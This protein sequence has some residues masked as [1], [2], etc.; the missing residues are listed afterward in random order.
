[1]QWFSETSE[2]LLEQEVILEILKFAGYDLSKL[3]TEVNTIDKLFSV[4]WDSAI[5]S[6]K[7]NIP[8]SRHS[9]FGSVDRNTTKNFARKCVGTVGEYLLDAVVNSK[10]HGK[11][12]PSNWVRSVHRSEYGIPDLDLGSPDRVILDIGGNPFTFASI[13]FYAP[14]S[15]KWETEA[16]LSNAFYWMSVSKKDYPELIG[17][18]TVGLFTNQ[19][20]PRFMKFNGGMM[21][22]DMIRQHVDVTN[23]GQTSNQVFWN[24]FWK[25]LES[26]VTAGKLLVRNKNLAAPRKPD[27]FQTVMVIDKLNP[28]GAQT[29]VGPCAFGKMVMQTSLIPKYRSINLVVSGVRLVLA[30]QMYRSMKRDI[31]TPFNCIH[32][33]SGQDYH[34]EYNEF[35]DVAKQ[36]HTTNANQIANILIKYAQSKDELPLHVLTIEQSLN[37]VV[38]AF[39]MIEDASVFD[40]E[41]GETLWEKGSEKHL[42][43][44]ERIYKL[45]T[46]AIY[47]EAH[48]LVTG[49]PVKGS[50][51]SSEDKEDKRKTSYL[52]DLPFLNT[53]FTRSTYWTATRRLNGSKRDMANEAMF[54]QVVACV[55]PSLAI[56][57]GY[58]VRPKV[59]PYS[60]TDGDIA[61]IESSM[62]LDDLKEDS[63]EITYYIKCLEHALSDCRSRDLPCQIMVF[64]DDASK[65]E[66]F[67]EIVTKYF[68]SE[69][70][71]ADVVRAETPQKDRS[72][73]FE[74]FSTSKFSVLFNYAIVHEGVDIDSCTGVILGRVLNEI[75]LVQAIGRS[76]RLLKE[77]REHRFG[78]VDNYRKQYG[79]VYTLVDQTSASSGTYWDSVRDIYWKITQA[80][81]DADWLDFRVGG[82]TS[83]TKGIPDSQVSNNQPSTVVDHTSN[84]DELKERLKIYHDEM[85]ERLNNEMVAHADHKQALAAEHHDTMNMLKEW[86]VVL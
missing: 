40:P 72:A 22:G 17:V 35:S 26:N 60:I 70:L 37:K 78:D 28:T 64:V 80:T 30:S 44:K 65:Q 49:D 18:N 33:M 24:D 47:D 84:S 32:V 46:E 66:K 74:R 86:G 57:M 36:H 21:T 55:M 15:K 67:A 54:G 38:K 48:N 13:K 82:S 8:L 1:M 59:I 2:S 9:I 76:Q 7:A 3:Q 20:E 14:F 4:V 16:N 27:Q 39:R 29:A 50:G 75:W 31:E 5:K 41:T 73:I 10:Q 11:L 69:G 71:V 19:S 63:L 23:S 12:V 61:S 56:K 25:E 68:S 51:V 81:N 58:S 45:C 83:Y 6:H 77:D 53:I 42:Y 79:L 34:K 52:F 85:I 62:N 43:W